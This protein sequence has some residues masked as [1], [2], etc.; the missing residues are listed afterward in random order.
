MS[1]HRTSLGG[2]EL[3]HVDL[4]NGGPEVKLQLISWNMGNADPFQ[5][6]PVIL[7]DL[8]DDL[9]LLVIGLQ[10]S[11]FQ[12]KEKGAGSSEQDLLSVPHTKATLIKALP[13]MSLVRHCHRAQMQ[14]YVFAEKNLVFDRISNIEE[15]I[16][17]TGFLHV[18]PNKGGLLVSL[19][20]DGTKLAFFSVH[21]AAHEGVDMCE[22]RN[23]SVQ[24]ILGGT[25]IGDGRFDV[26][27]QSHHTFFMGDMNY[28]CTFDP[29]VPSSLSKFDDTSKELAEKERHKKIERAKNK[30]AGEDRDGDDDEDDQPIHA[31][32][33]GDSG[34]GIPRSSGGAL[35]KKQKK[36]EERRRILSLVAAE[37]WPDLL[38]LD[39]LGRE[40]Q[41]CRVLSGFTPALPSFPPTFKRVRHRCI[42]PID[43]QTAGSR[44]WDL[45]DADPSLY[46]PANDLPSADS[47]TPLPPQRP[48]DI[49]RSS[50]QLSEEDSD[51]AQP[52]PAE[53]S[54]PGPPGQTP[55]PRARANG[56]AFGFSNITN[57][58]SNALAVGGAALSTNKSKKDATEFLP[59]NHVHRF[60]DRK[61][62]PSFTDRVLTRSLP[63]FV[64]NLTL[65]R[66]QSIENAESSDHKPVTAVFTLRT[67]DGV[68][69]ILVDEAVEPFADDAVALAAHGKLLE[70]VFTDMKGIN[71]AEMDSQIFG[72]G[73]DP[74]LA[75]SADP[76]EIIAPTSSSG[77]GVGVG[78][79][80]REVRTPVIEHNLNPD[81]GKAELVVPIISQVRPLCCAVLKTTLL[82]L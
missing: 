34:D 63:R 29:T 72:G 62:L 78:G 71:L 3:S 20:L 48:A 43:Q 67:E 81:W 26:A 70:V 68:D 82:L 19:Q 44:R 30:D 5:S 23:S 51:R 58:L 27:M 33:S 8:P 13:K 1:N 66:F 77:V 39:E 73:S 24:E 36:E 35:T 74:F 76:Q 46:Q 75:V 25:R 60:Y 18:F 6:W 7:G 21:L 22:I 28:R 52:P 4:E 64:S 80:S 55:K 79:G 57:S 54:T 38:K 2:L 40:V 53:P 47:S 32:T 10:E 11:T 61:R 50:S 16:E 49:E 42:A 45:V 56:P 65:E 14:L 69:G 59:H 9:G 12:I 15:R 41:A 37:A 31:T 17:N